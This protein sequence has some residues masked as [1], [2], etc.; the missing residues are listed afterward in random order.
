MTYMG[1]VD[2][3]ADYNSQK[4]DI[5]SLH[6]HEWE[7]YAPSVAVQLTTARRT[8]TGHRHS[9]LRTNSW[10]FVSFILL[11]LSFRYIDAHATTSTTTSTT[12]PTLYGEYSSVSGASST[13]G[14]YTYN[15]IRCSVL[16][17]FHHEITHN[18]MMSLESFGLYPFSNII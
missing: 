4:T 5:L 17:T 11:C 2:E 14:K 9:C 12:S 18:F 7:Q 8:K 6:S 10:S 3:Q 16:N 13:D 15:R 1:R